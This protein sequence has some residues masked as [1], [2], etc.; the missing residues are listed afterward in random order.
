MGAS[1]GVS[2]SP[3]LPRCS[4][5]VTFPPT[6]DDHPSYGW[7]FRKKRLWEGKGGGGVG[8]FSCAGERGVCLVRI[9]C[10][11]PTP[12]W[13]ISRKRKLKY[14]GI[15]FKYTRNE[16]VFF[17]YCMREIRSE[18]DHSNLSDI[19]NTVGVMLGFI[20]AMYSTNFTRFDY[21]IIRNRRVS[22][23]FNTLS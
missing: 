1:G 9:D 10:F 3:V 16:T 17:L 5:L 8:P 6:V 23:K 12:I 18:A 14:F 2:L 11:P 20:K 15:G 22:C 7:R 21:H 4:S 19:R 13:Q